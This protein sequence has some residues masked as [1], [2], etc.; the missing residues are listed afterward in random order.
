MAIDVRP[1][2]QTRGLN[3]YILEHNKAM[4]IN[5]NNGKTNNEGWRTTTELMGLNVFVTKAKRTEGI[6]QCY[7]GLSTS[8]V[9]N[10]QTPSLPR[11]T[12]HEQED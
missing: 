5:V 10:G 8:A 4:Q 9:S 12:K 3:N 1:E 7:C 6:L 2:G 11:T